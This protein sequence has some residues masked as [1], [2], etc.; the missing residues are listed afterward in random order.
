[1]LIDTY[2]PAMQVSVSVVW[3]VAIG[4]GIVMAF[5]VFLIAKSYR[6]QV[7]TGA[8]GMVGQIGIVRK[9]LAPEGLALVAGELWK[10]HSLDNET[11]NA[12]EEV[13][14]DHVESIYLFVK[15]LPPE[16]SGSYE[17]V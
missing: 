5:V 4:V 13:V 10:A 12:G 15:K 17:Q 9:P 6:R 14:V 1:M 11:I 16:G 3:S 2:D 7:A 8:E